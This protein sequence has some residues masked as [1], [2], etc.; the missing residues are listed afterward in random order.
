M[1][2]DAISAVR[3]SNDAHPKGMLEMVLFMARAPYRCVLTGAGTTGRFHDSFEI[4]LM[5]AGER[6]SAPLSV[7]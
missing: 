3:A 4:C 5:P 2:R 1:V 7:T 6:V